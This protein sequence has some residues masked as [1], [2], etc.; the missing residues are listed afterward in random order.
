MSEPKCN[1]AV[2]QHSFFI[3]SIVA[4]VYWLIFFSV[5]EEGNSQIHLF[6]SVFSSPRHH[7]LVRLV[8]LSPSPPPAFNLVLVLPV[9]LLVVVLE[10][11]LLLLLSPPPPDEQQL[12]EDVGHGA[13]EGRNSEGPA[14]GNSTIQWNFIVLTRTI[15]TLSKNNIRT[16]SCAKAP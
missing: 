2:F 16:S 5:Y 11:L 14:G 8:G 3:I 4:I 9:L 10:L 7:V 15:I 13:G 6:L 12:E 1:V